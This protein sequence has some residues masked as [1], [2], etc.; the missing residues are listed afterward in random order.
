MQWVPR[1]HDAGQCHEVIS[2][3]L[4]DLAQELFKLNEEECEKMHQIPTE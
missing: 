1:E 2:P 4:N 3:E